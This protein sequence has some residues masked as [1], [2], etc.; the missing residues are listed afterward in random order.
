MDLALAFDLIMV[1]LLMATIFYCAS[2]QR[3]LGAVR[4]VQAEMRA[5]ADRLGDSALRAETG[6]G[7]LRAAAAESTAQLE[8]RLAQAKTLVGDLDMLCH[9]GGKLA[10][11]LTTS[12]APKQRK[13]PPPPVAATRPTRAKALARQPSR[14]ERELIEALKASR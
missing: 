14:S 9:R 10:D 3:R 1:L 6:V 8:P 4:G 7:S 13:T 2:L 11:H 12:T 5:L